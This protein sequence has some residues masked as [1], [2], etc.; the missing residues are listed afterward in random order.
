MTAMS[1]YRLIR[2]GD[3][4]HPCENAG[5][6]MGRVV[7]ISAHRMPR[8]LAIA[9]VATAT[10]TGCFYFEP[11]NERPQAVIYNQSTAPYHER[12]IVT[13]DASLSRD[14][15]GGA[16]RAAWRVDCPP[17]FNNEECQAGFREQQT[18]AL[19]LPGQ[20]AFVVTLRV[21]DE[22]GA[23]DTDQLRIDVTNRL[24][25][26]DVY[27]D[28]RD[29]G[30]DTFQVATAI[31]IT[32][33]P[34]D[35]DCDPEDPS[36]PDCASFDLAWTLY[37]PDGSVPDNRSFEPAGEN[38]YQLFPDIAGL[39]EV[40]ITARDASGGEATVIVPIVVGEDKP[41]CIA[42]TS[43]VAIPDAVYVFDTASGP[44]RLAVLA[45]SDE[46]DPYPPRPGDGEQ[47]VAAFFWQVASPVT[48][49]E[50]LPVEGH[51]ASDLVID[52]AD[53]S[54]GDRLSVRVEVTDR[55]DRV[56]ACATDEPTCSVSND[57][58]LQRV[59]WELVVR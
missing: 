38:T 26:I 30:G 35:D 49:G 7:A 28:G 12:Q 24:P 21:T 13:L 42:Q 25:T 18:L 48:G 58:C 10:T 2:S 20:G 23:T 9:L 45:V 22:Q 19:A 59:T 46:L 41:P 43:P 36:D 51:A 47:G 37:P 57:A 15:G 4:P 44:R 8:A 31:D 17:G 39:W 54:P 14:P 56:I 1:R 50:L 11:I 3:A 55:A 32:A 5:T 16:I 53:F 40:E 34:D 29:A 33:I 27:T 52:P 6:V